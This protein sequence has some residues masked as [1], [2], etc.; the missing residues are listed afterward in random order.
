M[1]VTT[2]SHADTF[3]SEDVIT[4]PTPARF[5]ICYNN[6][7]TSVKQLS[8]TSEQWQRVRTIFS[9][10]ITSAKSERE[11]IRQAIAL[12]ETMIG[13][14]SGT[15]GDLAKNAG[16]A[17]EGQMDCID[18]STN[19]TIYLRMMKQDGLLK[20]HT[21]DDRET[22]GFFITGW[23]H[24]TAVIS[25]SGTERRFAVDSWFLKNGEP[26]YIIPIAEWNNGWQ[27]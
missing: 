11:H 9:T 3:V 24:T 2:A 15:S 27:P 21:V 18:E 23:P 10:G 1:L 26:P 19:T 6:T 8:L 4:D 7:C 17:L 5:S 12:L 22:R 13:S 25:E 16:G 14:M 20:F